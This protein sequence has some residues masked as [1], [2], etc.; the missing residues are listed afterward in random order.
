MF[1]T[2]SDNTLT[3]ITGSYL[4]YLF[5]LYSFSFMKK[6]VSQN[7]NN[8]MTDI[9]TYVLMIT[10]CLSIGFYTYFGLSIIYNTLIYLLTTLFHSYGFISINSYTL[11]TKLLLFRFVYINFI[12]LCSSVMNET[13]Q[14][15]KYIFVNHG[16]FF[17]SAIFL[18]YY[19]FVNVF[20]AFVF[21]LISLIF[22]Y[23]GYSGKL[24]NVIGLIWCSLFTGYYNMYSVDFNPVNYIMF[25]YSTTVLIFWLL[26]IKNDYDT[27]VLNEEIINKFKSMSDEDKD[28]LYQECLK[29]INKTENTDIDYNE[30]NSVDDEI[31]DNEVDENETSNEEDETSNDEEDE[32]SNKEDE[33]SNKADETI[34]D[35]KTSDNV[36]QE[37]ETLDEKEVDKDVSDDEIDDNVNQEDETSNNMEVNNINNEIQEDNKEEDVNDKVHEDSKEEETKELIDNK[38][39]VIEDTSYS[40][41]SEDNVKKN[42]NNNKTSKR[43]NRNRRRNKKK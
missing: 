21:T 27:N 25:F 23:V 8:F 4:F 41:K 9:F 11:D 34:N 16:Q 17:L 28:K 40:E 38:V 12:N 36:N 13:P 43:K 22:P 33:T 37:D 32:T 7:K 39:E 29:N 1:E 2:E 19:E 20:Y 24:I 42:T 15:L 18:Q 10:N 31:Y 6:Y 30:T 14:S 3:F 5:L 26:D 35:D